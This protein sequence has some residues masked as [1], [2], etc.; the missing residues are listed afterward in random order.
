MLENL[1]KPKQ[2]GFVVDFGWS[3]IKEITSEMRKEWVSLVGKKNKK[4][5]QKP[6]PQKT[7]PNKNA[8]KLSISYFL[9]CKAARPNIS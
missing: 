3:A 5:R 9:V 8:E 2:S 6:T 7:K 1:W 4:T